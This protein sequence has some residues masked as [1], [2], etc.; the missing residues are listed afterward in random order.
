MDPTVMVTP[1]TTEEAVMNLK[2]Q[3]TKKQANHA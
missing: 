2:R 1:L 3:N